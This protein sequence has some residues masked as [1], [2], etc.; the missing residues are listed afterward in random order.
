MFRTD[1]CICRV[2]VHVYLVLADELLIRD[3]CR[4]ICVQQCTEGQTITPTAAEVSHVNILEKRQNRVGGNDSSKCES[5]TD[6]W[7]SCI[8]KSTCSYNAAQ[9]HVFRLRL[10]Y[11]SST[12]NVWGITESLA[13]AFW[14]NDALLVIVRDIYA[15]TVPCR[16]SWWHRKV[17]SGKSVDINRISSIISST[18]WSCL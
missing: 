11:Q 2:C 1:W 13:A 14:E 18:Q 9:R 8:H 12:W 5:L 17:W 10:N 4:Q 16:N 3:V 7:R 15:T 6:V